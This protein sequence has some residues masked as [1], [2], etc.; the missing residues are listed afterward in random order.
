MDNIIRVTAK[1]N[2]T[3]VAG[4]AA[5]SL[6]EHGRIE[7][8]AIGGGA[9]N[10]TVKAIAITRGYVAPA[11]VDLICIPAFDQTMIGG[12]SRVQMK[13]IVEPR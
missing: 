3:S 10:Q 8:H 1:S 11:G 7:L 13:F 6:R 2:P 5:I 12:E 9:V 4:Y